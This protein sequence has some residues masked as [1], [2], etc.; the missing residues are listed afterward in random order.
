MALSVE[1]SSLSTIREAHFQFGRQMGEINQ[2]ITAG[3]DFKGILDFLFDSLDTVIFTRNLLLR[4][5]GR[6]FKSRGL[7]RPLLAL[8]TDGLS[9]TFRALLCFVNVGVKTLF[10]FHCG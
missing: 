4:G 7:R 9:T 8:F 6:F 5:L 3:E 1:G 10:L 2:K